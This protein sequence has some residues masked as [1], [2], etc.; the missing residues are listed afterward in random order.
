MNENDGLNKEKNNDYKTQDD[1]IS[2]IDFDSNDYLERDMDKFNPEEKL[3]NQPSIKPNLNKKT[4]FMAFGL[5]VISYIVIILILV[6]AFY[7]MTNDEIIN[8]LNSKRFL[9]FS[10]LF[11]YLTLYIILYIIIK[12]SSL[13]FKTTLKL[14]LPKR[15]IVFFYSSLIPVGIFITLI[16]I[17]VILVKFLIS[18]GFDLTMLIGQ[19]SGYDA[20]Y[21][22]NLIAKDFIQYLFLIFTVAFLPAIFEELYFRGLMF[23]SFSNSYTKSTTVVLTSLFFGIIHLDPARFIYTF[24]L[25]LILAYVLIKSE[26]IY[27][28]MWVHFLNNFLVVTTIAIV[29]N[30]GRIQSYIEYGLSKLHYSV[31]LL[32]LIAGLGLIILGFILLHLYKKSITQTKNQY[33]HI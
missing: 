14:K 20:I 9:F 1:M 11:L 23:T 2:N 4:G 30:I 6:I 19:F 22:S 3:I 33:Q 16:S 8:I 21:Q 24:I 5:V 17:I 25:G 31:Y 18:S 10:S 29:F 32:I 15:P 7:T 26:S 27:V 12:K 13:D 28:S